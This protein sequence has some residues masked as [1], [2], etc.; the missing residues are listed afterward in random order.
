MQ[1]ARTHDRGDGR[2]AGRRGSKLQCELIDSQPLTSVSGFTGTPSLHG[3]DNVEATDRE[4]VD[5]KPV[6]VNRP[7][8]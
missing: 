5:R 6:E 7:H 2:A 8:A 1:L 3:F 4:F